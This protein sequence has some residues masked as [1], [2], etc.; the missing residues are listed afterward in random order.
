[1]P[2]ERIHSLDARLQCPPHGFM[3]KHPFSLLKEGRIEGGFR[4]SGT[5]TFC[6]V[7]KQYVFLF[8]RGTLHFAHR[9]TL[10]IDQRNFAKTYGRVNPT[11]RSM[12]I[13]IERC[14]N[15]CSD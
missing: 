7:V 12:V 10:L 9:R 1:M 3:N 6:V 2:N 4:S 11:I 14:A 15:R 13:V 5:T 8:R